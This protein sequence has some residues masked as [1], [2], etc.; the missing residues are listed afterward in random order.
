M[1][2]IR[3]INCDGC[4][5]S[6]RNLSERD[7]HTWLTFNGGYLGTLDRPRHLCDTCALAVYEFIEQRKHKMM[8]EFINS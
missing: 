6:I 2:E 1:T 7:Q 3:T 4:Q 5:M 8:E